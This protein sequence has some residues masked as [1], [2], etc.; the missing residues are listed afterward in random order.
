MRTVLRAI[1]QRT[2]WAPHLRPFLGAAV[3]LG[4]V[5]GIKASVIGEYFGANN[6]IGFQIQAAYQSM[7]V[8]RLFAWGLLL[9]LL[10]LAANHLLSRFEL[11][12]LR[13]G[14]GVER[15]RGGAAVRAGDLGGGAAVRAGDLGGEE[16]AGHTGDLG[17]GAQ[18][19]RVEEQP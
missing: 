1:G 15:L 9:V 6:G 8:R 14:R 11:L 17:A 4:V 12:L 3:K 19:S 18:A 7:Q 2:G 13:R 16:A 5:L 10:I